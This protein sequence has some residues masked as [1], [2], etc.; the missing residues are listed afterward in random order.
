MSEEQNDQYLIRSDV[1]LSATDDK[2]NHEKFFKNSIQFFILSSENHE[3]QN[4]DDDDPDLYR[5]ERIDLT[6]GIFFR[7]F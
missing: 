4:V 6:L 1:F 5:P 3:T 2:T 7:L